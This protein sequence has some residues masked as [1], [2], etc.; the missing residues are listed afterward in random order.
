MRSS[1]DGVQEI[2]S[3]FTSLIES[4]ISEAAKL[5]KVDK[6]KTIM[7]KDV[8]PAIEK[9]VGKEHLTWEAILDEVLL[10]NP[11]DLGNISKG[12]TNYIKE[13]EGTACMWR[14]HKG[15]KDRIA[16]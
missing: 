9:I 13:A 14:H 2:I 5:A 11:T 15:W 10:Q 7:L 1:K 3:K 16:R 6:R 4:V 12:I 8:Q